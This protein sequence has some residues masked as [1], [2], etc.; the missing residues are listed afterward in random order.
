M[1]SLDSK[2][3][4]TPSGGFSYVYTQ[5]LAGGKGI[6]P[7]NSTGQ[8]EGG[9]KDKKLNLNGSINQQGKRYK[10]CACGQMASSNRQGACKECGDATHWIPTPRKRSGGSRKRSGG[11]RKSRPNKRRKKEEKGPMEQLK[12]MSEEVRLDS[13]P[14]EKDDMQEIMELL[15][16]NETKANREADFNA[17]EQAMNIR[18][19]AI[20]NREAD[21][22]AK[23][24]AMNIREQAIANREADFNAKEQ[25]M[26]I[27]E[28]A[29]ANREADFNAKGMEDLYDMVLDGSF[30]F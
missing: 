26:N 6:I 10:F 29:I 27:R 2:S 28:Q 24:Q 7:N 5:P 23:E 14:K 4:S 1:A 9:N 11:S 16:A 22:N 13:I 8:T 21:F 12:A 18:E 3:N 17:K 25:A 20:A 19:Q 30:D 15:H